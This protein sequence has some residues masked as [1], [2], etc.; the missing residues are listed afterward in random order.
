MDVILDAT[1][2]L[3]AESGAEGVT[4]RRVA[5]AAKSAVGSLYHFFP[6]RDSL[7]H[8]VANR[9]ALGVSEIT[10]RL[11][12]LAPVE[13]Q[14]M[15]TQQVADR[16]ICEYAAY[17]R[18]HPDFLLT[19]LYLPVPHLDAE[20][21]A[22]LQQILDARLPKASK[23]TQLRLA[24]I[25]YGI[26]MGGVNVASQGGQAKIEC[27]LDEIPLVLGAYLVSLENRTWCS[28]LDKTRPEARLR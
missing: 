18:R 9:H 26:L 21:L 6:S 11:R 1:E 12:A 5:H 2:G 19:R 17:G 4:M 16:L 27:F 22:L 15:S 8:A 14:C 23:E 3:I 10:T 13:W 20:F 28:N 7:L 24:D 25:I